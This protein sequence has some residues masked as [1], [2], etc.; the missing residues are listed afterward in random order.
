MATDRPLFSVTPVFVG[1]ITLLTQLPLQLFMTFWS[2]AFFGGM[3]SSLTSSSE[4]GGKPAYI[5]FGALA[6]FGILIVSYVG[7]KLNYAR[8]EYRFYADRVEFDEGFF[9]VNRKVIKFQDVKEVTL[10]KGMLQ[11]TCDLGTVY[12]ATLATGTTPSS[13]SFTAFGFGSVS[14]SGISVRDVQNP[15]DVFAKIRKVVD[16][17]TSE[18]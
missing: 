5:V 2:G 18:R 14:A 13:N 6:F 15:D 10:Q 9:S 7:K 12:L 17:R 16:A 3:F 1:W 8:T 4:I 11:R